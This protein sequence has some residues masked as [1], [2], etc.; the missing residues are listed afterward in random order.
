MRIR[1]HNS[2]GK[3]CSRYRFIFNEKILFYFNSKC[4]YLLY[5]IDDRNY[6][7]KFDPDTK[8][9]EKMTGFGKKDKDSDPNR[10]ENIKSWHWEEMRK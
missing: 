10:W 4:L 6:F 1:L 9:F 3:I 2:L 5:K 8:K 7:L